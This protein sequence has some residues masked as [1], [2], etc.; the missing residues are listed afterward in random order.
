VPFPNPRTRAVVAAVAALLVAAGAGPAGPGGK[1]GAV[2]P[3][4]PELNRKVVEFARDR[5]GKKVGD[6]ECTGLAVEALRHAGARRFRSG[7]LDGDYV[8]GRPVASF[9]EAMPGDVLQFRDAVFRGKTRL[10]GWRVLTWHQEYPHHTAVVDGVR[11][12]G[13]L[14]TILHQNV[15]RDDAPDDEK[16]RVRRD[17][18]RPSALQSGGRVWIYRPIAPDE[19]SN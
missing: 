10:S 13:K 2:A 4:V 15:G 5:V 8:W 12:G 14:V 11:D 17:T 19:T 16:Q 6:G 9:R 3:A 1:A 18:L 7:G